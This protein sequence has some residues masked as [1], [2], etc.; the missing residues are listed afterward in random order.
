MIGLAILLAI[1]LL[2]C[3]APVAFGAWLIGLAV[4]RIIRD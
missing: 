1:L 4:D 2:I 3:A